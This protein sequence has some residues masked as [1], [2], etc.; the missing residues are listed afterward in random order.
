MKIL[1][2]GGAGFIGSN[3]ADGLLND[4]R[5]TEVRVLDN[6]STGSLDNIKHLNKDPRFTF[7]QGDIRD[8]ETCLQACDGIDRITHQAALGSV[9]R[10][11]ADPLTSNAVN[12]SGALNV[13][14]AAKEKGIKRIVYAASSSTYGDH[15]G[16]PKIEDK[17]GNPLSPYA[18][19][20]FVNELY[21]RVYGQLYGMEFVGLRYFN[22]FG[23]RQN[24]K[25]PYAAVIPLFVKALMNNE[26]PV[27]NGDGEHSRDFTFV[28]NAVQANIKALFTENKEA[29]NQVYN[30]ACGERTTLNELFAM[31]KEEAGSQLNQLYGP[32]R[33][34]DVK[35]SL[36]DISKA[37]ELLGYTAAVPIR[38][39]LKQAYRWY[40]QNPDRL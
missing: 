14:T 10:S 22:I 26:A 16:L 11:I 29:V 27:M 35:H 5:V 25:G 38:E 40:A 21:A 37:G 31:L 30:I 36:A 8:Y 33:A 32:E 39:G 4:D 9:P 2:T 18:V 15:P 6:L 7:I 24:P 3:L 17:I 13:F 20:K 23:P 12:I 34:G 1:L 19:T 28:A